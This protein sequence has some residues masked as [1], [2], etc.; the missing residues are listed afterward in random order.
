MHRPDWKDYFLGIAEAVAARSDCE[1]SRVGAVLV[2]QDNR[3]LSTGYNGAPA[4]KPGCE[5]CPRR[6]SGCEPG[7]DYHHP[8]TRCNALHAEMNC[9]L[10]SRG[11]SDTRGATLYLTRE[12]CDMCQLVIQ[13]AGVRIVYWGD[14]RR[15]DC[16]YPLGP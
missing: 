1:R 10:Y 4:G 6:L 15:W 2:D 11:R 5:S 14:A 7:A 9:L 8:E 12:P 3:I 16:W 13:A